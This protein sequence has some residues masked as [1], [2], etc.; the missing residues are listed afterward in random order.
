MQIT[1]DS[2]YALINHSPN[3]R[4]LLYHPC[5][6]C[7]DYR[8]GFQEIYLWDIHASRVAHKYSGHSQDRHVIRSCFGGGN[9][10][11]SGSEGGSGKKPIIICCFLIFHFYKIRV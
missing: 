8:L 4:G 1:Q 6:T 9:F 3:V 10:V 7:V 5:G 2:Q 11:I